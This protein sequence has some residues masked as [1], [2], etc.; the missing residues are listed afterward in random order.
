MF[1]C[2]SFRLLSFHLPRTGN[3]IHLLEMNIGNNVKKVEEQ[4]KCRL[5]SAKESTSKD[6]G[7]QLPRAMIEKENKMREMEDTE[8]PLYPT[9]YRCKTKILTSRAER[10]FRRKGLL[11]HFQLERGDRVLEQEPKPLLRRSAPPTPAPASLQ[12]QV[13]NQV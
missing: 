10:R 9:N 11:G 1:C 12:R 3:Q 6:D 7:E 5:E 4:A 8:C 2:V 13:E